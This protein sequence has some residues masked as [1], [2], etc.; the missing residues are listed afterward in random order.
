[1]TTPSVIEIEGAEISLK[2][3][4]DALSA[5]A[6]AIEV[7]S[8]IDPRPESLFSHT[9]SRLASHATY[10]ADSLSNDI[11]CFIDDVKKGAA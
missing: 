9:I 11:G 4:T 3:G 7:L 2:S 8:S 1:M 5:I 6:N 10:L